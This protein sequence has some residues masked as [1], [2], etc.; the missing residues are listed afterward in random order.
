MNELLVL[1]DQKEKEEFCLCKFLSM[2]QGTETEDEKSLDA[3]FR[4]ASRA[5]RSVFKP[6][7]SEKFVNYYSCAYD[8]K[9]Q[10]QGP[11]KITFRLALRFDVNTL[12]Q[13]VDSWC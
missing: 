3:K 8:G 9:L 5:W 2:V 10:N 1:D 6:H 13:F 12:I 7:A 11:S 4:D